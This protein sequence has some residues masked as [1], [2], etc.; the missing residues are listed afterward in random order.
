MSRNWNPK[1]LI[2]AV[3]G[4]VK[5][6]FKSPVIRLLGQVESRTS[7]RSTDLYFP[8]DEWFSDWTPSAIGALLSSKPH[9]N[10]MQI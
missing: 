1:V 5:D 4:K 8:T 9:A 6:C 7:G 3:I 10:V 2:N